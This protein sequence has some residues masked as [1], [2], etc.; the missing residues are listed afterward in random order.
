MFSS[1]KIKLDPDLYARAAKRAAELKYASVHEFVAHLLERELSARSEE[2][3][4]EK[5]MQ[6]MKGLGYLQ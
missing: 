1:G 5:V 3:T 2:A 4:K 6:K